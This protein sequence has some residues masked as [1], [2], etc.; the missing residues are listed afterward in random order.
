M[1]PCLPLH[2]T[3]HV[4]TRTAMSHGTCLSS[5]RRIDTAVMIT[6]AS[7][8]FLQTPP[9]TR[10]ARPTKDAR[11]TM[12]IFACTTKT[13]VS[14]SAFVVAEVFRCFAGGREGDRDDTDSDGDPERAGSGAGRLKG[15][16]DI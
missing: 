3:C 16:V 5:R 2:A 10:S 8:A 1:Y 14:A 9:V 4:L 6:S 11:A 7:F 15:M 12:S 13:F